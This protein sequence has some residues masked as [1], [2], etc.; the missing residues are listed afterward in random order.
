R[1]VKQGPGVDERVC[2]LAPP[3]SP[4]QVS[5]RDYLPYRTIVH[6]PAYTVTFVPH[7]G[8]TA[9][10]LCVRSSSSPD[11]RL[12][13]RALDVR[14]CALD[15]HQDERARAL[16]GS[17]TMSAFSDRVRSQEKGFFKVADL[18]GGEKTLTISH[19]D[20]EMQVFGKTVDILNF[21]ETGRQLQL[22]QT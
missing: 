18:E 7:A 6:R 15:A 4:T 14:E 21:V 19:L 9:S 11:G 17:K 20:E 3:R 22:N 5:P 8:R 1:E 2:L 16:P 13:L 10:K 12:G